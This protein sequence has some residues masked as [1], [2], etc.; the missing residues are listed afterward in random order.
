MN[1]KELVLVDSSNTVRLSGSRSLTVY[2]LHRLRKQRSDYRRC[3][4]VSPRHRDQIGH[5]ERL[6]RPFAQRVRLDHDLPQSGA[7]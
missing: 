1:R 2:P 3:A 6:W 4:A 5:R 7:R